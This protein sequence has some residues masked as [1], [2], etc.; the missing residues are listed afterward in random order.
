MN[1]FGTAYLADHKLLSIQ[2]THKPIGNFSMKMCLFILHEQCSY[3]HFE[4]HL[5][6]PFT[7]FCVFFFPVSIT[8]SVFGHLMA[9]SFELMH[10]IK[11]KP[12]LVRNERKKKTWNWTSFIRVS[13]VYCSVRSIHRLC[14][15][16]SPKLFFLK[17]MCLFHDQN[18]KIFYSDYC[19][20]LLIATS[21]SYLL[22]TS[23]IPLWKNL[24]NR[25]NR[26]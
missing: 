14:V 22:T 13:S 17:N 26:I 21:F 12:L 15:W 24:T 7:S 5:P 25:P 6:P 18:K 23:G 1:T 20:C 10:C 16:K 19:L 11:L 8:F 4:K 2:W 9:K 3:V